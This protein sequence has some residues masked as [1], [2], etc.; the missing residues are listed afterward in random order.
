MRFYDPTFPSQVR[1]FV[2]ELDRL[3]AQA[4]AIDGLSTYFLEMA[5]TRALEL[6]ETQAG[7][8]PDPERLPRPL[9]SID[10]L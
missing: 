10:D 1:R 2:A 8:A 3:I 5:R 9:R 7:E 6:V 4:K